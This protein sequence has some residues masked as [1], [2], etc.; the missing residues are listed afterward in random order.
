MKSLLFPFADQLR[1]P[2][3]P[4]PYP[5][6]EPDPPDN[7]DVPVRDPDPSQP[8]QMWGDL[9]PGYFRQSGASL[10]FTN[11]GGFPIGHAVSAFL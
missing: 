9:L 3:E 2:A 1:A 10:R 11:F 5:V 8:G 6:P 4:S 7:P